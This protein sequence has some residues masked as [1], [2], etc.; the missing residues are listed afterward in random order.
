MSKH[1]AEQ[2]C[3][4][5]QAL[6]DQIKLVVKTCMQRQS[7]RTCAVRTTLPAWHTATTSTKLP[8]RPCL[9]AK[10]GPGQKCAAHRT[11]DVA[12]VSGDPPYYTL[13]GRASSDILKAGTSC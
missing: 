2:L 9:P 3:V 1:Q 4:A 8:A 5:C 12:Q 13:L 10:L 7:S 11:G 6:C